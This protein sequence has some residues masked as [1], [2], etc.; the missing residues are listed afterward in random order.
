MERF[1]KE[2]VYL[3]WQGAKGTSGMGFMQD[4]GDDVTRDQVWDQVVNDGDYNFSGM[5]SKNVH[6]PPVG[7]CRM[8]YV[9]GRCLKTRVKWA[10][11]VVTISPEQPKATYQNWGLTYRSAAKVIEA[12]R[13]NLG[14]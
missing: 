10:D 12:A 8:D 4:R 9:F 13:K 7:E 2:V 3:L 11:G 5:R 14:L 6:V 1:V